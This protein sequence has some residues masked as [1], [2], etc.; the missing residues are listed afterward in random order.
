MSK[1]KLTDT[2]NNNICSIKG[3]VW[4]LE[5]IIHDWTTGNPLLRINYGSFTLIDIYDEFWDLVFTSFYP[6]I[7]PNCFDKTRFFN[8]K[9]NKVGSPI[10]ISI[11]DDDDCLTE[12][13]VFDEDAQEVVS[14]PTGINSSGNN[15]FIKSSKG[16]VNE[17]LIQLRGVTYHEVWRPNNHY[18]RRLVCGGVSNPFVKYSFDI[19]SLSIEIRYHK[20]TKLKQSSILIIKRSDDLSLIIEECWVSMEGVLIDKFN[21]NKYGY[22][23]ELKKE[24]LFL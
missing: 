16:I 10:N 2:N 8:T 20:N 19:N 12:C 7:K 17:L 13:S 9:P 14:F 18:C 24:Y 21:Y 22:F 5:L 23:D 11:F 4:E 1:L 3:E 15:V 6:K